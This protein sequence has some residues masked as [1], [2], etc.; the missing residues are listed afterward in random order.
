MIPTWTLASHAYQPCWLSLL[1]FKPLVHLTIFSEV[2]NPLAIHGMV[3]APVVFLAVNCLVNGLTGTWCFGL[4]DQFGLPLG[5]PVWAGLGG[6]PFWNLLFLAAIGWPPKI[7]F[8]CCCGFGVF[9]LP[10]SN[11]W[12]WAVNAIICF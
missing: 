2:A 11:D 12:T 5:E 8:T 4:P 7:F 3:L 10:L 6:L 9:L 1:G